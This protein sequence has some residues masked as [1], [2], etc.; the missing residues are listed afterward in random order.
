MQ[1]QAAYSLYCEY[2]AGLHNTLSRPPLG[3]VAD[4]YRVKR[5]SP[6]EFETVW[7]RWGHTPGLQD[8]WA[9]RFSAD[10]GADAAPSQQNV[11]VC[12]AKTDSTREAA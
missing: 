7:Q 3:P 2:V 8:T 6:S 9:A 5:L 12:S 11:S 10:C 1:F 4:K